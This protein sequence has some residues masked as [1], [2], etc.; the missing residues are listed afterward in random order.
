MKVSILL[1]IFLSINLVA[2]LGEK[3][4]ETPETPETPVNDEAIGSAVEGCDKAL[5]SY[6]NFQQIYNDCIAWDGNKATL[7]IKYRS[8]DDT[9]TGLGLSIH[10]SSDQLNNLVTND[11]LEQDL[12][13]YDDGIMDSPDNDGDSS[14]DMVISYGWTSLNGNWPGQEEVNLVTLEF[15]KESDAQIDYIINYT[16]SSNAAGYELILGK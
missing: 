9:V 13:A 15:T 12:I 16:S 8:D 6:N 4:P 1:L 11:R 7:K 3:A 5:A 10:Y 14:T 2:C